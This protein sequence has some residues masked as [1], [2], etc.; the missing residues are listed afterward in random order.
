MITVSILYP[1]KPDGRFDFTYYTQTHMA[2][3]VKLLSAHPGY[4]NVSI[5]RG[6]GGAE[7]GQE[8]AF[9][10]ACFYHFA[11]IE[12]FI[13]AFM[14]HA[15]ELQGDIANYTNIEPIIQFNE[16]LTIGSR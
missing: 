6:L 2:R 9:V 16:Q 11:S 5:E 1:A 7:P 13:A 8:P 12:D 3:A 15:P 14:P 4:H 10:A